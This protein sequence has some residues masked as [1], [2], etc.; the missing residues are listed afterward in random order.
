MHKTIFLKYPKG[1]IQKVNYSDVLD[2]LYYSLAVV[3]SDKY[4]EKELED[5]KKSL[6]LSNDSIPLFDIFSRNVYLVKRQDVFNR[7][8]NYHYRLP[9][10]N[11]MNLLK[12]NLKIEEEK[13]S[14]N[15]GEKLIKNI[16]F[17]SNFNFEVL[18]NNFYRLV[19]LSSPSSNE[20]TD[21]LK[22]SFISFTTNKPYYSKSELVNLAYNQGIKLDTNNLEDLSKL[23]EKI[24]EN[25]ISSDEIIRHQKYIKD[26]YK[27]YIQLYTL[28]GS[29]YWNYY[30]R[31]LS[32]K[33]TYVEMQIIKL[34]K[35]INNAPEFDKSYSLYR[36]ISNDDYLSHLKPGDIFNEKS[37]I[38]TTRNPFYDSKH[39]VF[40]FILIKIKIPK[41]VKGI[42]LCIETYSLFPH[43]E[44]ILL[45]PSRLKLVKIV[46]DYNYYHP[47]T[48]VAQKINKL[49]E[50]E[51]IESINLDIEHI[52][53]N[54]KLS[55]EKIPVINWL[56]DKL[57]TRNFDTKV[58][59]FYRNKL[60]V[61]NNKRYFYS[62]FGSK[63]LLFQAFYL[64]DNPVYEKYFFLQKD[65]FK[66]QI[67]FINQDD[68]TGEINL[69]IEIRDKISV[70]FLHK[71]TGS[72]F[73]FKDDD[74]ALFIS[75]IAKFFEISQVII[76]NNY[77][78]YKKIAQETQNK[79]KDSLCFLSGDF[80]YYNKDLIDFMRGRNKRF[81]SIPGVSYNLKKHHI[82]K[83][84]KTDALELFDNKGRGELYNLLIKLLKKDK[85]IKILDYY[86][87]VHENNFYLMEELNK[88]IAI[89]D[90]NLYDNVKQSPW[91]NSY[92]ILYPEEYLF[93]KGLIKMV[94]IF[95]SNEFLDYLD[96]LTFDNKNLSFNNY[97]L[98]LL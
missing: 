12:D 86:L 69:I 95:K 78:S 88:T 5:I 11:T 19:F 68:E 91:L 40:G 21:C 2:E 62:Y 58:Y 10:E 47:N 85:N 80:K 82:Q 60:P 6:S 73:K 31:N 48:K 67:Y 57:D 83:L 65:K 84:I 93:D 35:I 30:L 43:E 98:G 55:K 17:L 4:N 13:E 41:K 66:D 34:Q 42:A 32:T 63:K 76:H 59:S 92:Y 16:N 29:F 50:F 23:C 26:N 70:N 9:T 87:Y 18:K 77:C 90:R 75:S 24:K 61:F 96:K 7:V 1:N 74:L 49:Y 46:N 44:E 53:K 28:L 27:A 15:Y 37:F 8:T 71:F 64:D 72:P 22:P 56:Q 94:K 25:D 38:S 20:L 97:R 79:N 89:Y 3:Y 54:Y 36:F 33:D 52:T 39:S 51:L 14:K 45:N 81:E